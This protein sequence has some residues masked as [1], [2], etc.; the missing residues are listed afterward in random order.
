MLALVTLITISLISRLPAWTLTE[1]R[2]FDYLSTVDDPTPPADGPIIVAI[3]EPALADINAQWP[4]PRSLHAE[5]V[6]QLRAAGAKSH[7]ARYH[8]GRALDG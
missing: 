4:W 2:T 8:H 5:L 6:K 7:R 1:L 3:D